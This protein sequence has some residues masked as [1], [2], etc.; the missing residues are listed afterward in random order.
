MEKNGYGTTDPIINIRASLKKLLS[1]YNKDLEIVVFVAER[2][3]QKQKILDPYLN[4]P[5][6]QPS[7]EGAS[8]SG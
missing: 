8:L 3:N 6:W 1:A 5:E 7:P 4:Q 2:R